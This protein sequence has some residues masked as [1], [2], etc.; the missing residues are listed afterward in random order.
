M[1][2][3]FCSW[4]RGLAQS[5]EALK[6][7]VDSNEFSGIE[8][9]IV[10]EEIDLILDAGLKVS[11][12]NPLRNYHESIE[13]DSFI[14]SFLKEPTIPFY[15]KKVLLPFISFHVGRSCSLG[16]CYSKQKIF[17]NTKKNLDYL[18]NSIDKKIILEG[19]CFTNKMINE[20]EFTKINLYS[21]SREFFR[22]FSLHTNAEI[23]IDVAHTL[24][25]G[26]TR[27]LNDFYEESIK[28]YFTD[29]LDYT[30]NNVF[31]LHINSFE[32]TKEKNFVD[33]HHPFKESGF[34]SNL[35]F[36]CTNEAISNCSNLKAIVLEIESNSDP[37]NHARIMIEQ[38]KLVRKKLELN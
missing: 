15:S 38:A 11:L 3:L 9:S 2:E 1:V 10:N 4:C 18:S 14:E 26:Q 22:D 37:I 13:S 30:K 32:L 6:L 16:E 29:F 25:S 19:T 21:T 27:I 12:H 5:R 31:E 33:K 34:E 20:K 17:S 35:V 23:L 24:V 8:L 36:E 7:L 28:D